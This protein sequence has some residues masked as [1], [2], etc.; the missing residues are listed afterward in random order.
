MNRP[1]IY[2]FIWSC[3]DAYCDMMSPKQDIC[4]IVTGTK[5]NYSVNSNNPNFWVIQFKQPICFSSNDPKSYYP[6]ISW[7]VQPLGLK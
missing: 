2:N 7:P 5:Y 4:K 6:D 3:C 1:L